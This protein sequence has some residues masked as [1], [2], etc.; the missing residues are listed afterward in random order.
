MIPLLH[1][2]S[3]S[4]W[5]CVISYSSWVITITQDAPCEVSFSPFAAE[6]ARSIKAGHYGDYCMVIKSKITTFLE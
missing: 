4:P 2:S 6:E 3:A 5:T 1:L